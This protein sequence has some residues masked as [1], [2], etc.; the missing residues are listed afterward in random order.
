MS[1]DQ[2]RA[3]FRVLMALVQ[4]KDS[5]QAKRV[6][7]ILESLLSVMKGQARFWKITDFCIE[8]LIRMAKK[9]EECYKAC[10]SCCCSP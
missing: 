4:M 7:W 3:Y 6:E 1:Y 8:H 10:H 2:V 5:L 9:S